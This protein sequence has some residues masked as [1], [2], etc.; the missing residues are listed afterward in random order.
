MRSAS[1]KRLE[2]VLSVPRAFARTL[3]VAAL[4]AGCSPTPTS[5]ALVPHFEPDGGWP[6]CSPE[7]PAC[8][9]DQQCVVLKRYRGESRAHCW[10]GDAGCNALTCT[11]GG[12]CYVLLSLP[13]GYGCLDPR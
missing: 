6:P 5:V 7:A 13:P 2:G 12:E 8:G 9:Q 1:L 3:F 11:N 10:P 4:L